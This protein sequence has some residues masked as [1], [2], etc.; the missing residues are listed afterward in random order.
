MC[1][2][3]IRIIEANVSST[4]ASNVIGTATVRAVSMSAPVMMQIAHPT[5]EPMFM[6]IPE[7]PMDIIPRVASSIVAPTCRPTCRLPS[8]RPQIV[9]V[10]SGL[11]KLRRPNIL[12]SNLI[13]TEIRTTINV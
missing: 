13:M 2:K 5:R 11:S 7:A 4:V 8:S 9:Q 1:V 3:L 6:S 10:S 12:E